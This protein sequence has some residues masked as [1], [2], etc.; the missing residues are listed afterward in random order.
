LDFALTG[1]S[2]YASVELDYTVSNGQ[3]SNASITDYSS[4]TGQ[5]ISEVAPPPGPFPGDAYSDFLYLLG[6]QPAVPD[7]FSTFLPLLAVSVVSLAINKKVG[8][9]VPQ[10]T[11]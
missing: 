7:A 8:E 10:C 11:D 9:H 6:I 2:D 1:G 5:T 3:I 4:H